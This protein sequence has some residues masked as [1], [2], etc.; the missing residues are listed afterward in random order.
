MRRLLT[1]YVM[2]FNRRRK[3]SGHLFQN[4]Y[5]SILCQE[6][7]YQKELIRY[8]HLNPLRANIV[9]D[10]AAF[11]A[12]PYAGHSAIMEK[13]SREWQSVNSVLSL[14]DARISTARRAYGKYVEAG[15]DQGRRPE[16]M[17]GAGWFA[18]QVDGQT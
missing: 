3:R 13:C 2:R 18:V 9:K 11:D 10:L 1:G 6:D 17:G 5:K 4:R 7:V 16:L 12:Y 14:F 8:I 15:I